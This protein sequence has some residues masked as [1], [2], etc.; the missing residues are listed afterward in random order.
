MNIRAKAHQRALDLFNV[1]IY[2]RPTWG[3]GK[4]L[5]GTNHAQLADAPPSYDEVAQAD[6]S[7][8]LAMINGTPHPAGG[9]VING[10]IDDG[11]EHWEIGDHP[12]QDWLC[13]EEGTSP[14]KWHITVR[15]KDQLVGQI[16]LR[17][18]DNPRGKALAE[19]KG[20]GVTALRAYPTE[21]PNKPRGYTPRWLGRMPEGPPQLTVSD[22]VFILENYFTRNLNKPVKAVRQVADD[23]HD[24]GPP[25]SELAEVIEQV[26]NE[27]NARLRNPR[28]NGWQQGHC[29]FHDDDEASLSVNFLKGGWRCFAGCGSGSLWS[30]AD[31]LGIPV[32]KL[33]A[34]YRP[35]KSRKPIRDFEGFS[36]QAGHDAEKETGSAEEAEEPKEKTLSD[37]ATERADRFKDLARECLPVTSD[38]ETHGTSSLFRHKDNGVH[39]VTH[40]GLSDTWTVEGNAQFKR[41]RFLSFYLAGF[42]WL[43]KEEQVPL[44]RYARHLHPE[45]IDEDRAV[46]RRLRQRI[47]NR[48]GDYLEATCIYEDEEGGGCWVHIYTNVKDRK[49][50]MTEF[51]AAELIDTF[52]HVAKLPE[53]YRRKHP[54]RASENWRMKRA[55]SGQWEAVG[56]RPIYDLTSYEETVDGPDAEKAARWNIKTW[57]AT[58]QEMMGRAPESI[59]F[60]RHFEGPEGTSD[61]EMLIWAQGLG[62]RLLPHAQDEVDAIL[63]PAAIERRKAARAEKKSRKGGG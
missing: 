16:D 24:Q 8:G 37:I 13:I 35:S 48:D 20:K 49:V 28:P 5:R 26:L 53:M 7:G 17:P 54:V 12:H 46:L 47:N 10:D 14:G 22:F 52:Q 34:Q 39:L 11:P 63:D 60:T 44:Y 23:E 32:R 51:T 50:E 59:M 56:V 15:V 9:Y 31:R 38:M 62:F 19:I 21:P 43:L 61:E 33:A 57:K 30:L 29:P 40:A 6:F 25:P 58:D 55:R 4:A 3:Q 45:T 18:A 41:Q 42:E 27:Q 36:G 2:A 1:G